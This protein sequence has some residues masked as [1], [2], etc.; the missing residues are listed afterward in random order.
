MALC[1]EKFKAHFQTDLPEDTFTPEDSRNVINRSIRL[2]TLALR[3]PSLLPVAFTSFF[4]DFAVLHATLS[5]QDLMPKFIEVLMARLWVEFE[6]P[7]PS[8]VWLFHTAKQTQCV[9]RRVRALLDEATTD[10]YRSQVIQTL[11]EQDFAS[12]AARALFMTTTHG[13]GSAYLPSCSVI[14][15]IK[16]MWNNL[17][18]SV[19]LLHPEEEGA[20]PISDSYPQHVLPD[21]VKA[22]VYQEVTST[23]S[24][25][26]SLPRTHA[27]NIMAGLASLY[28]IVDGPKTLP[29]R[30]C[31]SPRC[32]NPTI[33]GLALG[34]FMCSR[35]RS[36]TYCGKRCQEM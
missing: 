34:E 21:L 17:I 26:G 18:R 10:E 27:E 23:L 6:D 16:P 31:R 29:K 13:V 28:Y 15:K 2:F 35:C 19:V 25:D 3:R 30:R 5:T 20:W 1:T 12:L 33:D 8:P 9:F 22:L 11:L 14:N 24:E 36:A 7:I 4:Y 32:A